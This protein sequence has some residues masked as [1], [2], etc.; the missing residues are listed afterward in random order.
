M[1]YG[2]V[3]DS[4]FNL[5]PGCVGEDVATA[6]VVVGSVDK[7]RQSAVALVVLAGFYF[8]WKHA[9]R[10]VIVDQEVDLAS[11]AVVVIKEPVGFR[12]KFHGYDALIDGPEVDTIDILKYGNDVV[13]IED[14]AENPHMKYSV[15][16]VIM[17]IYYTFQSTGNIRLCEARHW[18]RGGV[19]S[20]R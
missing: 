3:D 8:Q 4:V 13:M 20:R 12:G 11:C 14:S 7:P 5:S 9:Q 16:K 6:Y 17:Q 1:V 15:N 2:E 10:F 18:P 19:P